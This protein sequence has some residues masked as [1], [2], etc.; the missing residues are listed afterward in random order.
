[1]PEEQK[2]FHFLGELV[3]KRSPSLSS[4]H[5]FKNDPQER[6]A[7]DL[8]RIKIGFGY[9]IEN[10]DSATYDSPFIAKIFLT[11]P[12]ALSYIYEGDG[13]QVVRGRELIGEV[14]ILKKL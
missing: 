7:F 9:E 12:K 1:M 4:T 13:Y 3:L 6:L 8:V 14:V 5:E 11:E 2:K 10:P